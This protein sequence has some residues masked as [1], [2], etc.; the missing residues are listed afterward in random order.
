MPYRLGE[1]PG[2]ASEHAPSPQPGSGVTEAMR[3]AVKALGTYGPVAKGRREI[4]RLNRKRDAR[5][6]LPEAIERQAR[7]TISEAKDQM[8][9]PREQAR[10]RLAAHVALGNLSS[11]EKATLAANLWRSAPGADPEESPALFGHE[12]VR[13]ELRNARE[14]PGENRSPMQKCIVMAGVV[15]EDPREKAP[16]LSREALRP[17]SPSGPAASGGQGWRERGKKKGRRQPEEKPP[18]HERGDQ[19]DPRLFARDAQALVNRLASARQR[20][21]KVTRLIDER[22]QKEKRL[23]ELKEERSAP[24]LRRRPGAGPPR[25]LAD[26]IEE[27]KSEIEENRREARKKKAFETPDEVSKKLARRARNFLRAQKRRGQRDPAAA[28]KKALRDHG[29]EGLVGAATREIESIEARLGDELDAERSSGKEAK[30]SSG[31]EA[32]RSSRENERSAGAK[33]EAGLG[34]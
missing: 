6:D 24:S 20:A 3:D 10:K 8:G 13:R 34:L 18:L 33:E 17:D 31:K 29:A 5:P 26:A 25:G 12:A 22:L 32:G 4:R 23:D 21:R 1:P 9:T 7:E 28:M 27:K 19:G 11:S 14:V 30:R 2:L 15:G 16:G